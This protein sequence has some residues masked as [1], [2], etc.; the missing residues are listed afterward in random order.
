MLQDE[1]SL[2]GG[3]DVGAGASQAHCVGG[4]MGA[5][6]SQM[7]QLGM[8]TSQGSAMNTRSSGR[9]PPPRSSDSEHSRGLA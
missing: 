1:S 7:L 4:D 2:G 3:A 6:P 5:S 9:P 8:K